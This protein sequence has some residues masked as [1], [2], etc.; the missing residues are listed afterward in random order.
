[1]TS[2]RTPAL[3]DQVKHGLD[4]ILILIT[5]AQILIGFQYSAILTRGF[6]HL[7]VPVQ[8]WQL[9]GLGLL[10]L[11]LILIM[12]PVPYHRVIEGGQDTQ[13]FS[14]YISR[15]LPKEWW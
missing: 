11:T 9:V 10:L 15:R 5:G 3:K 12:S 1:M 8:H 2:T 6:E 13:R 4:E 7:S 14:R